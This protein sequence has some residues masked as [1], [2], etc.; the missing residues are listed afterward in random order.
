MLVKQGSIAFFDLHSTI[1]ILKHTHISPFCGIKSFT[2]Y[3]IYIKTMIVYIII[4]HQ[5][6]LH[7]TIFI[8]KQS[9]L[10]PFDIVALAFTFYNIYIKTYGVSAI[11]VV[12]FLIYILQ[13][14]Y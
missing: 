2:F 1:F 12:I 4:H 6:D 8:L 14:L 11:I 3:N 10:W 7:S 13:Y 5:L 9:K